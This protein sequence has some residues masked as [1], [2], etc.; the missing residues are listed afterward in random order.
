MSGS[1]NTRLRAVQRSVQGPMSGMN[2][3]L[4]GGFAERVGY[5]LET[6][7]REHVLDESAQWIGRL[8]DLLERMLDTSEQSQRVSFEAA[9]S[10]L[11]KH[12]CEITVELGLLQCFRDLDA[13]TSSILGK[14][15][16]D[17][18]A[19]SVMNG[20]SLIQQLIRSEQLRDKL[21]DSRELGKKLGQLIEAVGNLDESAYQ[22]LSAEV[23]RLLTDLSS[24]AGA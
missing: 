19:H 6:L 16:Y 4:V 5:V 11:E 20:R 8:L 7:R 18:V 9:G 24:P 21:E 2:A 12:L 14:R 3:G 22:E 23:E 15:H 1:Y 10:R 17:N 13:N